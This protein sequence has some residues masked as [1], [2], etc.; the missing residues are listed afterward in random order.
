MS[1]LF[2]DTMVQ[3]TPALRAGDL[4]TCERTVIER[5]KHLPDSPFRIAIDLAISNRPSDA[6]R[7]FDLFLER[8]RRS[9]PLA[10]AYTEMNGFDI[11]P[12]R[13]YCDLFAYSTYGGHDDY[14]WLADWQSAPY[15]DFEINGLEQL[16]AVYAG[17]AFRDEAH[18][19]ASYMSS[20]L[21]VIKFQRFIE[22]A[23]KQMRILQFPLLVTAH[24][25]D[26][27]AEF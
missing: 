20:L 14:D 5:L 19:D 1:D 26:F 10:A 16:Q 21:V 11:N 3:L 7:H 27:I 13:W 18:R 25:F 23:A 2:F 8:E 15:D 6:A 4:V 22:Q 12:D 9:M 17:P 24:D